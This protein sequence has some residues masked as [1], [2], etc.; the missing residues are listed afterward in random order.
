MMNLSLKAILLLAVISS[1]CLSGNAQNNSND[2]IA[3]S[4]SGSSSLFFKPTE[5]DISS[6]KL[7]DF[8]SEIETN[9]RRGIPSFFEK[10]RT[11][12]DLTVAYIGGSITQ[13]QNQYR[14]QSLGFI[15]QM[16]PNV[17]I[18]GINA[19]VSGSDT[20]LAACRIKEQVLDN[21]PDLIFIEFAVNGGF[22]EGMEGMVRQI[23]KFNSKIDI[24]FIYTVMSAQLKYY[25]TGDQPPG[26]KTLEKIAN[27][28]NIPSIHLGMAAAE[29]AKDEKLII[30]GNPK[31][32]IGKIIFS[33]DGVHPLPPGGGKLYAE[34]LA[35]GM[36]KLKNNSK[37]TVNNIPKP[38]LQDNW[39][40]AKM[41]NPSE[42]MF[43]S[44]WKKID[45]STSNY[46]K[47]FKNWFPSIM[48]SERA[49]D[50]FTFNF[51]G[52][53]FGFFDIGGPES[54]QVD[55]YLDGKLIE[56]K[57][58]KNDKLFTMVDNGVTPLNRFTAYSY[59]RYRGQYFLIQTE[60]KTHTVTFKISATMADKKTIL[61]PS[62]QKDITENFEKYNRSVLY[63]GKILI[64]GEMVN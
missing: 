56:L 26:I 27:H 25:Q 60:D 37:S 21:H 42:K 20:E 35:R 51:K 44:G 8:C 46:L 11:K 5:A 31:D 12:K 34:A 10:S 63:L 30:K 16:L 49:G 1:Y 33:E 9:V 47:A 41:I 55:I 3:A 23:M 14:I 54:G 19:G 59:N 53:A 50:S 45:S 2:L 24:C 61:G 13:A 6:I 29:L 48:V 28:Y 43:S 38:L 4:Q 7:V 17:I 52:K 57:A 40:D 58:V 36:I 62:K 64:R 22:P 39:E 18:K 15:Q 32:D